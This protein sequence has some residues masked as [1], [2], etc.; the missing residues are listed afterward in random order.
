[1]HSKNKLEILIT[2]LIPGIKIDTLFVLMF[3]IM[4][5]KDSE[6]ITELIQIW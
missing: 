6:S 1:M 5:I 2:I 4:L 3:D